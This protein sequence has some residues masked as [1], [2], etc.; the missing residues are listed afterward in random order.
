MVAQPTF[1]RIYTYFNTKWLFVISLL[2][3]E[4]GS[5]ICAT[6]PT[7]LALI[8]GRAVAGA[9]FAGLYSGTLVVIV[10]SMPLRKR[11]LYI[12][13]VTSMFAVSGVVGPLL[14]GLITDSK[15]LTWRFCF[16]INLRKPFVDRVSMF[17][18]LAFGVS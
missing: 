14:G 13:V 6:S 16:W 10:D 15:R 8:I 4:S 5:I 18:N 7:S 3:F 1:G 9:G 11:P 17:A 12:G 2:V